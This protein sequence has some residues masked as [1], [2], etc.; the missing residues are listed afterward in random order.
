MGYKWVGRPIYGHVVE[1]D[2]PHCGLAEPIVP[3]SGLRLG[4]G[5][6]RARPKAPRS[7]LRSF[8][9]A[10]AAA[11]LNGVALLHM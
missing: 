4:T 1:A 8:A 3:A 10:V 7:P 11:K 5:W 9:Q 2:D 6:C